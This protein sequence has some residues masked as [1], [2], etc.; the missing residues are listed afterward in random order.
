MSEQPKG[1]TCPPFDPRRF[2]AMMTLDASA[3]WGGA[4]AIAACIVAAPLFGA[5]SAVATLL[6]LVVIGAIWVMLTGTSA[7]VWRRARSLP[8]LIEQ[9]V[10]EAES[11]LAELIDKKPLQKQVRL[12]LLHRMAMLRHRQQRYAE[13]DA[14]C[15]TLLDER[16]GPQQRIRPHL[17]LMLVESNLMLGNLPGAYHGLAEMASMKLNL[18]ESLQRLALQT[19]YELG[20]GRA[21]AA[22]YRLP[23]KLAMAELM[24]A[25]QAGAMHAMLADA[26]RHNG[27]DSLAQ[28]LGERAQLLAGEKLDALIEAG[29]VVNVAQTGVA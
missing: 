11:L 1:R 14:I 29:A 7:N 25:A 4:L 24:P 19:R 27:A 9:D 15:R 12:G 20:V 18:I 28:W 3:R 16:L 21:D 13:T 23:H 6:A 5:D 8:M 17:L 10:A 22:L 2:R 26:A